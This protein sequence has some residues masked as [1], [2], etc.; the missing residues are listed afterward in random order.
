MHSLKS[1]AGQLGVTAIQEACS[2]GESAAAKGDATGA[3]AALAQV[4][5]AWPAA[6]EWLT[7]QVRL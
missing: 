4:E 1:S 5:A 6:R 2:R 7:E 3:D